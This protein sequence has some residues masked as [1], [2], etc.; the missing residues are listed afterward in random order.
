[1]SNNSWKLV[2]IWY[3]TPSNTPK[4]IPD[5]S[6]KKTIDTVSTF[7]YFLTTKYRGANFISSSKSPMPNIQEMADIRI[8]LDCKSDSGTSP[9]PTNP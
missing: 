4:E 8:F 6:P 3:W 5:I 7:E 2:P 1:M 9:D